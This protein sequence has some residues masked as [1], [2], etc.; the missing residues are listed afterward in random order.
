MNPLDKL[1]A[2]FPWLASKWGR[3]TLLV[4]CLADVY[5]GYVEKGTL[6]ATAGIAAVFWAILVIWTTPK[7]SASAKSAS[8]A[9]P[10]K[11]RKKK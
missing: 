10:P 11:S 8:A 2:N 4:L 3:F 7:K 1:I 5:V 6:A 9:K